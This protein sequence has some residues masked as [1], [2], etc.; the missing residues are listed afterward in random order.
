M[1]LFVKQLPPQCEL[2]QQRQYASCGYL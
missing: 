1:N 2:G